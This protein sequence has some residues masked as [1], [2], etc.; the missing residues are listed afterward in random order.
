MSAHIDPTFGHVTIHDDGAYPH[1]HI[2]TI[3]DL[4][5][6]C[7]VRVERWVD[8]LTVDQARDVGMALVGWASR[9][10]LARRAAS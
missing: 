9:K 7:E 2:A 6:V 3:V 1:G 5:D 10:R 4:G 8:N